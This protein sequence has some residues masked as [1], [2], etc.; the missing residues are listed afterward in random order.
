MEPSRYTATESNDMT[1]PFIQIGDEI[2]EM[3]DEEKAEY[4]AIT[5]T[6]DVHPLDA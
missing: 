2:R 4:E 5:S 3:T 1:N 6:D